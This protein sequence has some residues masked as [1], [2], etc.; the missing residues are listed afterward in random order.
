MSAAV[1]HAVWQKSYRHTN[2]LLFGFDSGA[3]FEVWYLIII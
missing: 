3:S 2:W 1:I